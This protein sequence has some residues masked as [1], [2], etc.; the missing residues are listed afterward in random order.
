MDLEKAKGNLLKSDL[1]CFFEPEGMAIVGSFKEGFFG[2]YV[3]I[4]S[5]LSAGYA[6]QI[7]PI[8][9]GYQEVLGLKVYPHLSDVQK[10]L[11][12]ALIMINA[13]AVPEIIR[14]C[15][16]N[17]IKGV[18]VIADGFAER[19]EDGASL[20]DEM[21][22][23]AR[24]VGVR[25]IGPNTAGIVN[26]SNGF[27]PC[28]YEAG[29]YKIKRGPIAIC[30]QTGM[31]NPQAFYYPDLGFGVS[32]ICDLGNK[33]DLN[34]C[35]ILEYLEEDEQTGV[36]SM[37]LES[38]QEGQR[39]LACAKRVTSKKP[40]LVVKSGR[41]G[42]GAIASAS[43]TGSLAVD[44]QI[45][46][47]TC[48][49]GGLLRLEEFRELFEVPK[50]FA[51]QPLP[52]GNR[53]AIVTVTGAVAVMAIDKG[54]E[55][56]LYLTEVSSKNSEM[57]NKIFP[58]TGKMPVDIGPMMAAVKDAF[59]LYPQMLDAVMGDENVDVLFNVLWANPIG[60]IIE[61]YIRA[62][63]LLKGRYQKPLA[64]WVYGPNNG[65]VRDLSLR[66]EDMGFP[67]FSKPETCIKALGLALRYT[68][69]KEGKVRG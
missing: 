41:T 58:G 46:E 19:N 47:A 22:E 23:T 33:S 45:F 31:I 68:H 28:P 18:V 66:L 27:N 35:D 25:I 2:G 15:G 3:V 8:N 38:I 63:E 6:G 32:K 56:G 17:G 52:R 69:I 26:T 54:A 24:K 37:Y 48:R 42:A 50:I 51:S 62:Y 12:L 30:A 67:V 16:E 39:F 7:Y 65:A 9:P 10:K 4:K 13:R 21:V 5:L 61:N 49:Q 43:H 60:N 11:D 14:E 64:T 1:S 55:Y 20:Q 40:V 36:I 44:D 57:L 34:E 29:Y 59:S 53:M